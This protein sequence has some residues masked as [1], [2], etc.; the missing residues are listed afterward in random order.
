MFSLCANL[1]ASP[2]LLLLYMVYLLI[3]EECYLNYISS[4]EEEAEEMFVSF[5]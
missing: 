4:E 1:L 2:V 3:C 5:T